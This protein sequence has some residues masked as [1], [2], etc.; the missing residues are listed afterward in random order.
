[1][2]EWLR[3][4]WTGIRSYLV[5]GVAVLAVCG[6]ATGALAWFHIRQQNETI[7]AKDQVIVSQADQIGSLSKTI[8]A[9]VRLRE[10]EQENTRQL[11]DDLAAIQEQSAGLSRQITEL[12][13]SNAEVRE[14][15]ATR[16]PDD[17]RRLLD[18]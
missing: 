4:S 6:L 10:L 8:N 16:I 18:Q 3:G 17:L 2:I 11:Q 5:G 14:F 7:D 9:Q 12:E 1:M 13:A 15:M